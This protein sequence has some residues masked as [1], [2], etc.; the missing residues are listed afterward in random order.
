M[1]ENEEKMAEHL[2]ELVVHLERM[3]IGEY[4]QMLQD[5]KKVIYINFIA[6][7]AR[8]IGMAV[9]FTILGALVVYMLKQIVLLNLPIISEF[10]A[11]IVRMVTERYY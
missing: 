5:S 11:N 1:R 2:Q 3:N 4:V 9:G 6:G 7:L 8:G 10:I